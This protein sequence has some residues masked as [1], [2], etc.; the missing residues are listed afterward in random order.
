MPTPGESVRTNRAAD[1]YQLS[2]DVYTGG[3]E[4]EPPHVHRGKADDEA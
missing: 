1:L 2:V 3:A 4:D